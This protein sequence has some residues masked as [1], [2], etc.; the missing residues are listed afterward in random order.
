MGG[1]ILHSHEDTPE[2]GLA[3]SIAQNIAETEFTVVVVTPIDP[4]GNPIA[5][6]AVIYDPYEIGI[7]EP[8]EQD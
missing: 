6:D 1:E 4:Q 7:Q 8:I 5:D 3:H 2:D